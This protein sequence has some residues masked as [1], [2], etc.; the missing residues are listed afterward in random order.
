MQS[1]RVATRI[2]PTT[3]EK[4]DI[5]RVKCSK[6]YYHKVRVVRSELIRISVN[7]CFVVSSPLLYLTTLVLLL[8]KINK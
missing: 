6:L 8:L 2:G 5:G 3:L 7:S 4:E 1:F